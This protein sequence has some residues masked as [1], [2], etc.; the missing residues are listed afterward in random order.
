[1]WAPDGR[2]LFYRQGDAMMVVDLDVEQ[3]IEGVPRKLFEGT[4]EE[5]LFGP[6]ND[7]VR[8]P[9]SSDPPTHSRPSL[10]EM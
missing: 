6:S 4:F 7:L 8:P 5:D 3:R 9:P 10:K 1:M 2:E